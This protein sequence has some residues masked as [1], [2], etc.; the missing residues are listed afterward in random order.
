MPTIE[1]RE[2]E[3]DLKEEFE[4]KEKKYKR[5]LENVEEYL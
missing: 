5:K 2:S 3:F 1:E 4:K